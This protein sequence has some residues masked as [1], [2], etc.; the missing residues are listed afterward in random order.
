MQDIIYAILG[1][2]GLGG[3]GALWAFV[4]HKINAAQLRGYEEAR[5]AQAAEAERLRAERAERI[6]AAL[7]QSRLRA[8]AAIRKQALAEAEA[9]LEAERTMKRASPQDVRELIEGA[10]GPDALKP[11][12]GDKS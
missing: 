6:R 4:Q 9:K 8:E 10:L 1:L 2:I 12:N 11:G 3:A 7:E 5:A